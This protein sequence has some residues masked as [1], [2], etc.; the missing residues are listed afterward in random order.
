MKELVFLLLLGVALDLSFGQSQCP[1]NF[2]S[3]QPDPSVPMSTCLMFAM[4]RKRTWYE[5]LDYCKTFGSTLARLDG[6]NLHWEVR[7]YI[8]A[9]PAWTDE[10]FHIGCSDEQSEG[11]WVWTNGDSVQLGPPHWLA[12]QPDGRRKENFGCIYTPDFYYNSCVNN[13]RMYAICQI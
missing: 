10:G 1:E 11:N 12:G 7:D 9:R 2:I 3:F 4:D 13:Q 8:L 5:A 6:G